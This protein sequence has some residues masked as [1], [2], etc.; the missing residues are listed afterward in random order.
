MFIRPKISL[1]WVKLETL[2]FFC[3]GSPCDALAL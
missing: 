2:I 1:E 3:T